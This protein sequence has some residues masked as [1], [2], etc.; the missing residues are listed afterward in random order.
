M[1]LQIY[2]SN[3]M[4]NLVSALAVVVAEPLASPFTP[5]LI[6]VQS[7]GMQRWLAMELAKK[8]GVWANC[9]YP[10]PN[11]MVWDLFCLT[12]DGV[13][14]VSCF[15]PDVL[16]WKIMGLLPE[17]L[18]REEFAPL[19][20]Y[21]DGDSD[22]LKRFQ[23]AGK[24]AD[25]FDQ[26]TLFRPEMILEWEEGGGAEWQEILWRDL[27]A[28]GGSQHRAGLK[29]DFTTLLAEQNSLENNLPERITVFGISYLPQY[30]LD[31]L[32]EIANYTEVN[33]FL[34]S[35]CREYWG[36]IVSAREQAR[37]TP[38]EGDYLEEGNP[39]LASLGKLARDFSNM[40]INS[41]AE[42]VA[43]LELY[44]EPGEERL[45]ASLQSDILRLSGAEE[46]QTKRPI[47]DE[48]Q[49]IQIHS[50]H[51]PMRE[52]ETLHD[53]LLALLEREKGLSPRDIVV[54]TP[55]IET[56]APYIAMVFEACQEPA[57]K[58]PYSI[59]DRSLASEGVVATELLKLLALPGSRLSATNVFDILE[60][61]P[62]STR[63]GLDAAELEVIRNWIEETR[64]RWGADEAHRASFGLPSYRENSWAAGLDRLLLGYAMPEEGESL[65]NN[66]LPFDE[67]EGNSTQTLGK[68]ADFVHKII[69]LKDN[70]ARSRTLGEWRADIRSLLDDFIATDDESAYELA[71]V[72]EAVDAIEECG[73]KAE[74]TEKVELALI[75]TWLSSRLDAEQKGFG[76]MTGGITF[77][78]MLPMRSIP[79]Q[80][81]ALVGMNDNAFPRQ[82]RPPG[83][84]LIARNPRPG[85]RS[86]RDEDRYLFLESLLSARTCFYLS[87]VGQSVKDNSTI[88]PS[89]LVSE[90]LDSI[91][92]SFTAAGTSVES[93]LVTQ[94]R[95]QAFSRA[96]FN[97]T[98]RLFSY[99]SENCAALLEAA[100]QSKEQGAF[101]ATALKEPPDELRDVS[102]TQLVRF[103]TN[104]ARYLLENRLQIRLEELSTPLEE[105]EPFA[106]GGLEAYN[107]NQ[108]LLERR[109][110][111][112]TDEEY[113]AIAQC[114][115]IL[116]PASHGVTVFAA[117][118][119]EVDVLAARIHAETAGLQPREPLYFEG[120]AGTFRLSGQLD[121]LWA[122]KKVAYRCA[123]L[124]AKDEIR[125]W[126]EHLAL[127]AFAPTGYPRESL[128]IMKDT[129]VTYTPVENAADMLVAFLDCYWK[130]LQ[131]PLRF[132]PATSLE[133]VATGG[134][135]EKALKKW[136]SGFKYT[137]EEDEPSFHLCFGAEDNPLC[138]DFGEIA[139][140]LLSHLIAHRV[141][142]QA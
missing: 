1:P 8:L 96:Y 82:S 130:G 31:I 27:V 70:L 19:R 2:T 66:L 136:H 43:E 9:K 13:P 126:I 89:V 118:S 113:L 116:P 106:V 52:I 46:S 92:R 76:F 25:T 81:V 90:F 68:F 121:G 21:L 45:L 131:M 139:E 50:C 99:S 22:G 3:R 11:K 67:M 98:P 72:A 4:E 44:A 73:R 71:A 122:D 49:S 127:N 60:S 32:A 48:D 54:M 36:D 105:R 119:A 133:F 26:Y 40:V 87:Y 56:Y 104:P 34:L 41:S 138:D 14:D 78:A 91:D 112:T 86:L 7:K 97:G 103:F 69:A 102:L 47:S 107:L 129:S 39:L 42:A 108:E 110:R 20:Y 15:S 123:K 18:E 135:L 80:V 64:I 10:F 94:H 57:R 74:F 5:E 55:D 124:K 101:I 61:P 114:R 88:P 62:I 17:Y 84:D 59:A 28:H 30:H 111:G 93:R 37:R 83:F 120:A 65:F 33:L 137:G 141:K 132:F 6:V 58:I 77:C 109:L 38:L 85:D 51:S 100:Q 125:A 53:N 29:R 35:P 134:N 63:F 79:F 24:I 140:R 128:L 75:R 142:E 23:L 16:T 117:A 95:L 115:G 12:F